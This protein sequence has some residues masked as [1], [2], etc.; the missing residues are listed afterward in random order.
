LEAGSTFAAAPAQLRATAWAAGA[1]AFGLA[2][3]CALLVLAGLRA[4][5]REQLL[6][7]EAA[8]GQAV[9]EMAA[10]VAH[11]LRNPLGTIRAG[12][13]LLREQSASPE[14]VGDILS[15][16]ARL[17][18]LTT[19]FLHF[20]R[21]LPMVVTNMDLAALTQELWLQLRREYPD[22]DALRIYRE[23]DTAVPLR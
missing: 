23:G 1:T 13:E 14:L 19:Q 16:V 11:E 2:T 4:A 17:S 10:M 6:R 12:A 8:R 20:S 5:A 9:R 7:A 15:E 22:E 18:E 3:L 21:D